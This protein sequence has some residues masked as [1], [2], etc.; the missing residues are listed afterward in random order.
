MVFGFNCFK[1]ALMARFST[2]CR[3]VYTNISLSIYRMDNVFL[4]FVSTWSH[5]DQF[6]SQIEALQ[7]CESTPKTTICNLST[8]LPNFSHQETSCNIGSRNRMAFLANCRSFQKKCKSS[9]SIVFWSTI[10]KKIAT[11]YKTQPSCNF[12]VTKPSFFLHKKCRM[13]ATT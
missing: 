1:G 8:C 4:F 3:F 10:V 12:G 7:S 6:F 5:M 13:K 9:S 2:T 11:M